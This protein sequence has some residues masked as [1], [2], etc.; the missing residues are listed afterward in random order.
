MIV[1]VHGNGLLVDGPVF[2]PVF[3]HGIA[4]LGGWTGVCACVVPMFV[5]GIALLVAGPCL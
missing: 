3:I 4:L 2:M 1:F 5:H